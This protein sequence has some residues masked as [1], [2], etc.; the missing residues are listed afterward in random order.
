M[1]QWF[2]MLLSAQ[3]ACVQTTTAL[4]G[5]QAMTVVRQSTA[6]AMPS[7]WYCCLRQTHAYAVCS[8]EISEKKKLEPPE[9][10]KGII[11]A[12]ERLAWLNIDV[13]SLPRATCNYGLSRK[14]DQI[15]KTMNS[16]VLV[17]AAA[18]PRLLA[19]S[20]ACI[21]GTLCRAA[22][23]PRAYSLSSPAR[24]LAHYDEQQAFSGRAFRRVSRQYQMTCY[25]IAPS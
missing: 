6:I 8:V 20:K 13:R 21:Q 7:A 17:K 19:P 10:S 9:A 23:R 22:Q 1:L 14:G 11:Y 25:V 24:P 4:E 2:C 3:N 12:I 5:I 15:L 16:S 18:A